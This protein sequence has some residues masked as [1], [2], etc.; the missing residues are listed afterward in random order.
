VIS[1]P[2][3]EKWRF[4]DYVSPVGRNK[5]DEWYQTLPESVAD[6]FDAIL[7]NIRDIENPQEWTSMKSISGVR[8]ICELRFK[9]DGKQYRVMA[10]FRKDRK[11]LILLVGC[12][13]TNKI[14]TARRMP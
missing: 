14:F 6:M 11:E 13:T 7:K 4:C 8:G 9:A 12:D 1:S 2:W 3:R 5:I 10:T